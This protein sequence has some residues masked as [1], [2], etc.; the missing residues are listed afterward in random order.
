MSNKKEKAKK[1]LKTFSIHETNLDV[2]HY[3][4]KAILTHKHLENILNIIIN[5]EVEKVFSFPKEQRDFKLY[6]LLLNPMIMK[7]VIANCLGKDKTKDNIDFVNL[8]LKDEPLLV[9]L[10]QLGTV[11]NDKN[12]SSIVSRLKK[13]WSNTFKALKK[14][15]AKPSSFLGKPST[16]K[17]K[18]LS[19]VFNYS[20]PLEVSKFSMKHIE[21]DKVGVTIYKKSKKIYLKNNDYIK[22]KKINGLTVCLSH[23]HIYYDF[24]YHV[25][26]KSR[27]QYNSDHLNLD[28]PIKKAGLDIGVLNLFALFINDFTTQSLIY[29]NGKLLRYN[30]LFNKN[31]AKLN[32]Q[33]ALHVSEYKE[34]IQDKQTIKIPVKYNDYGRHLIKKRSHLW[35]QRNLFMD[36]EMQKIST[37]VLTFLKSKD[38]TDLVISK[39]LQFTKTDGSIKMRKVTKQKFYQIPFGK[40]L[41]LIENKSINFGI[42]VIDKNEA[43]T[44]KTSCLSSN[45]CYIQEQSKVREIASNELNGVRG[46]KKGKIGRGIFKDTSINKI[47]NSD[48]NGA[49]NHI[50]VGF[51]DTDLSMFRNHLWKVCNPKMIKSSNEF[52]LYI[53]SNSK[54]A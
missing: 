51:P 30:A 18:K 25:A 27:N 48:L 28:K 54:A 17:A 40:L 16:P 14:Y 8:A 53:K 24:N 50:K 13:D 1:N 46:A 4:K 42:N 3:F 32:E 20:V 15:Y 38:V 52:D 6:N 41:N 36:G 29:Q 39:N 21:K 47:I 35:N 26:K 37:N 23:G 31:I 7:A 34:I 11:L 9:D 2:A 43:Y 19:K 12:V 45:V 10:K 44:S 22:D 49:A 33:I 5:K